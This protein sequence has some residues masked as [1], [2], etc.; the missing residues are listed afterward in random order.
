MDS[1]TSSGHKDSCGSQINRVTG[2]RRREKI[3][4]LFRA[5][6]LLETREDAL[7]T[8]HECNVS[9]EDHWGP[10]VLRFFL[11]IHTAIVICACIYIY[12]SQDPADLES[13]G[14]SYLIFPLCSVI[15][16]LRTHVAGPAGNIL[17]G[18]PLLT[19][20]S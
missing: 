2:A 12:I 1:H 4:G 20:R 16:N 3:S 7:P 9:T 8:R 17:P 11:D 13:R 19:P 14:L 5:S 15:L 6:T 10:R 18:D